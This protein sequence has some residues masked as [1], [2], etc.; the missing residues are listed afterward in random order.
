[1][2]AMGDGSVIAVIVIGIPF[3]AK[4]K[5]YLKMLR[6]KKTAEACYV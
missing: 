6:E 5:M 2:R 4:N 3:G 1:M